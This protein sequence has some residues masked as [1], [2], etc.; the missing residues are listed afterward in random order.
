MRPILIEIPSKL[1]FVVALLL[2]VGSF[3]R[4]V[5]ERRKDPKAP[6]SS[7][8]L[9]LL[10]AAWLLLGLRAGSWIP[11]PGLWREI[12]LPVPIYSYGVMLGSS[13]IV[14][15]FLAMR[16]AKQDGIPQEQAATIYMW[17]AVWAIVGA[18]VLYIIVQ[19]REF[20][21]F[22]DIFK[23]WKGGLVAYGGLIGGF[24]ASWYNCHK[25]KIPLLQWA[26][27]SSTSVVLGTAIT[28]I[29]CLLFGC[30]YGKRTELPW[31]IT[32]PRDAPAWK[33]HVQTFGLAKDALHSYPIHPTQVY[34]MIA[35][36]CIFAFCLW[37]RKARKF[38]GEVFVAW[39]VGYGILR[40]IIEVFRDDDQRGSVG[41]LSTSQFI[42]IVATLLA[43]GL[44]VSLLKRYR[45]D[46]TG[47]RLWEQP[48]AETAGQAPAQNPG[49]RRKARA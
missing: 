16:F 41:P 13:M 33:D 7:T 29:G 10:G 36:L 38:S 24:L 35:A 43:S 25:R 8:A 26:D 32:F 20:D 37:R 23:V 42:G 9:T 31:A 34:E 47:M 2:A 40:P 1:L 19:Y 5:R 4:E 3:V 11:T 22:I 18:R 21:S 6:R 44:F 12:W 14:G 15:W 49:K 39:V 28:R 45:Q 27:A 48:I 17:T 46:P 30:D